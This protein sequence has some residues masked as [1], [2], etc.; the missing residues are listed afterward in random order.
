MSGTNQWGPVYTD[1]GTC[2]GPD[3]TILDSP[4][5]IDAETVPTPPNRSTSNTQ[6]FLAARPYAQTS[7]PTV[8]YIPPK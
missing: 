5:Q 8:P 7:P 1:F 2:Y 6:T 4:L 3:Y